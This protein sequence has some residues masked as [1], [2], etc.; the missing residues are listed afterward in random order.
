[1]QSP[2]E[3]ESHQSGPPPLRD[4][5]WTS[6]SSAL[7]QRLRDSDIEPVEQVLLG[8]AARHVAMRDGGALL[9]LLDVVL[10][11]SMDNDRACEASARELG[12]AMGE[13]AHII[14]DT[15][16]LDSRLF[17]LGRSSVATIWA[18][19]RSCLDRMRA[20]DAPASLCALGSF[21]EQRLD[22]VCNAS[23]AEQSST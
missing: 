5:G 15:R 8:G 9:S 14:E 20:E 10:H 19:A 2:G 3:P 4:V 11:R 23:R 6:I 16:S 17:A 12:L 18:H 21:M 1:M 7:E 13:A 22:A